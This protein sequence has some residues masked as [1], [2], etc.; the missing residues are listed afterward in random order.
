MV[1]VIKTPKKKFRLQTARSNAF[2][3]PANRQFK[4]IAPAAQKKGRAPRRKKYPPRQIKKYPRGIKKWPVGNFWGTDQLKLVNHQ[5]Y[6]QYS[7][8]KIEKVLFSS[9]TEVLRI[10][11]GGK[12]LFKARGQPLVQQT[13][14]FVIP[15]CEVNHTRNDAI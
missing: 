15:N 9:V 3:P 8:H 7:C 13:L 5:E 14:A 11:N 2:K 1:G 4:K 6:P 10:L 12:P